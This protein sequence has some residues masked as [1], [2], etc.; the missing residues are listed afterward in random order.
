MEWVSRPSW[1]PLRAPLVWAPH[2]RGVH[3][4]RRSARGVRVANA[5]RAK[6]QTR[7]T[8]VVFLAAMLVAL[9]LIAGSDMYG[10]YDGYDRYDDGAADSEQ[11]ERARPAED[12]R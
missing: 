1:R 2:A 10:G 4:P 6:V 11:S 7:R 12:E 5:R 9:T 3:R 8:V